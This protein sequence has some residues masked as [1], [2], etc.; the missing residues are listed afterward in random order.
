MM[1]L[2][3]FRMSRRRTL[4]ASMRG[5]VPQSSSMGSRYVV[6]EPSHDGLDDI[7]EDVE[8]DRCRNLDLAPDHGIGAPQ[9]DSDRG[10][11]VEAVWCGK[12]GCA[13]HAASLA[14]V[15]F[16]FQGRNSSSFDA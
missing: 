16:Q 1:V 9:L 2:R 3:S 7:V 5:M 13:F 14:G 12:F 4:V 10:D 8:R 15:A 11:L 6:V